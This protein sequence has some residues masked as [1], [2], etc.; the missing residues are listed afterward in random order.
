MARVRG[1]AGCELGIHTRSPCERHTA[2]WRAYGKRELPIGPIRGPGFTPTGFPG[3]TPTEEASHLGSPQEAEQCPGGSFLIHIEPHGDGASGGLRCRISLRIRRITSGLATSIALSVVRCLPD[4]PRSRCHPTP[5]RKRPS[6]PRARNLG[7]RR[8]AAR[9][10]PPRD[11]RV[12]SAPSIGPQGWIWDDV[13]YEFDLLGARALPGAESLRIPP[14]M[15]PSGEE[16]AGFF[17]GA[18]AGDPM[19]PTRLPKGAASRRSTSRSW[20]TTDGPDWR[21]S[22]LMEAVIRNAR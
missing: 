9:A 1:G 19:R 11:E 22:G 3:F 10:L 14:E 17:L 21:F 8:S 2:P 20:P 16:R 5:R 7:A 18:R 6:E 15:W 4:T 13:R 12:V